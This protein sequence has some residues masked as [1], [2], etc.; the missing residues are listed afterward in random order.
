MQ[1]TNRDALQVYGTVVVY[2]PEGGTSELFGVWDVPGRQPS[3][4]GWGL[5]LQLGRQPPWRRLLWA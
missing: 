2:K 4:G 1:A 3:V 5:L